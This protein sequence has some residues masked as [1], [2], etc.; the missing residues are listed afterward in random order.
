MSTDES[1]N[2]SAN[3]SIGVS[4]EVTVLGL[5]AMGAALA[6]AFVDAG[7]RTTVWN[8]TRGKADALAARGAVAAASAAEAVTAS[9]LVV[10][11]LSSY[12]GVHE[13]V[14]PLAGELAGRTL[15]NLTSGSPVHAR[16]TAVWAERSRAGY[17][18]GV[19]MT[20]PSGVGDRGFLQLYA[21]SPTAFE[22]HRATLAALG[23]PLHVGADTALSSVYDTALLGL[24]WS[25]LTGWLHTVALIGADG[26]GGNVSAT[27]YTEVAD[28]WMQTVRFFMRAYAPQIDSGHYPSGEF[29]LE[30]HR[31][32]M[33]VLVHACRLRGI[34]SR[35]AEL[36]RDLADRAV[37]AGHAG[38][39]YARLIEYVRAD[40][41]PDGRAEGR[42]DGHMEG[43]LDG[44]TDGRPGAAPA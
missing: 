23:E 36:F 19:I 15:V 14:G 39:S 41:R 40:G 44:R 21:G 2:E 33:D 35:T 8:R 32:T 5:G 31:M 3:V 1:V 22:E 43:R 11:C 24:M 26:P 16:E 42:L 7:H 9:P 30:L 29:P 37:A 12:G 4:A 17:L 38:D 27:A 20:T 25:T 13:V 10:I 34:D 6:G 28:R 18:D